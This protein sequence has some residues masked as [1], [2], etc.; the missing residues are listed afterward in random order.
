MTETPLSPED[1][2][3][4]DFIDQKIESFSGY[5]KKTLAEIKANIAYLS[6]YQNIQLVGQGLEPLPPKYATKVVANRILPAVTNDIAVATKNP[7][8]F[9]VIPAGSDEDDKATALVA[10]KLLQYIRRVNGK[11]MGRRAAVLWYDIAG[12]GWRKVW[13]DPHY[14]VI[15]SNPGEEHPDH[16][17]EKEVDA[18][19]FMGEVRIEPVANTE[20][21]FDWRCKNLRDLKWIIHAQRITI[22][23]VE[24]RFGAEFAASINIQNTGASKISEFEAEVLANFEGLAGR[25]TSK[26]DA[27]EQKH[28]SDKMVDY[29]EFW[30][31]PSTAL[32]QGA[33]AVKVGDKIAANQP[34]PR[35]VY[36]HGELPFIPVAPLNIAG[37]TVAA[38]SRISQAR[39]L[40]REYNGLRSLVADNI[41]AMGNSVFMVPKSAKIAFKR[42]DNQPGNI[43]EYEGVAKPSRE[44]GVPIPGAIFAYMED[45]KR[46]IDEVFSF[47][48]AARGFMSAGGPDSA[49]GLMV[50]QDAAHT[51]LGPMVD[52]FDE[53]DE[54]VAKQALKVGVANYG[55]R[56]LNIVGSDNEWAIYRLNPQE[57]MGDINVVVRPGSSMPTNKAV[58]AEKIFGL[59]QSGVLGDP[60]DASVKHFV[61][62]HMDLG[63]ASAIFKRN[64]KH[65]NFAKMEFVNAEKLAA[66]MPPLPP[67]L[68]P[69]LAIGV[70]E[71]FLYMPPPNSFDDH[72]VHIQEH[73]NDILEKYWKFLATG[74]PVY[75]YLA[76]LMVQHTE[77]HKQ[78]QTQTM[79][80][81]QQAQMMSEAFTKGQTLEQIMA[82]QAA[83]FES[84]KVS[85]ADKKEPK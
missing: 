17:P 68:N 39:P 78:L 74:E 81:F 54:R 58:E 18:P 4:S 33:Y 29:C 35:D 49:K 70:M 30:H 25:L 41:D 72:D 59:W 77:M 69:E 53:A 73:T 47:P 26:Q 6:G 44:A 23:E 1:K 3:I 10:D 52:G 76:Q 79:M 24:K 51:Q 55:G 16:N 21:I 85:K 45:V 11:D 84:T 31:I 34:Y 27:T 42:I 61:L 22:G 2:A 82:K 62:K 63:D 19:D 13:W 8:L 20:I 80:Q 57:L 12:I 64:T 43:V 71:Q 36:P 65:T 66:Q 75:Q 9:D 32:P 5:H 38:P 37:V 67:E 48:D 28:R 7:P 60:M 56:T 40:Q 46:G 83:A 15:G 50:L 14:R